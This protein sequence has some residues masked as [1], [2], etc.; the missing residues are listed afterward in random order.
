VGSLTCDVLAAV[1]AEGLVERGCSN[2]N[3]VYGVGL[4][5]CVGVGLLALGLFLLSPISFALMRLRACADSLANGR[6]MA[7]GP[8]RA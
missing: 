8:P 3:G 7:S 2:A 1:G 6:H 5:T 4:I